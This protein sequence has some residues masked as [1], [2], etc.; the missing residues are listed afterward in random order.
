MAD[1]GTARLGLRRDLMTLHAMMFI[2]GGLVLLLMFAYTQLGASMGV[3]FFVGFLFAAAGLAVI[4]AAVYQTSMPMLAVG[5][6]LQFVGGGLA[7]MGA[8]KIEDVLS[9]LIAMAIP[10]M[11]LGQYQVG[12]AILTIKGYV[13][14]EGVDY[15][16]ALSDL[17]EHMLESVRTTAMLVVAGFAL[18]FVLVIIVNFFADIMILNSLAIVGVLVVVI[19]AGA[20]ILLL[21]KG[22]KIVLEEVSEEAALAAETKAKQAAEA[23][24]AE[25]P[26]GP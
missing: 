18:S 4:G 9:I 5:S 15:A 8:V 21:L 19:I 7:A 16:P 25:P 6:A 22:G 14:S 2:M 3:G 10:P 17:R 12:A 11:A 23:A 13:E 26:G 20:A 24:A 1:E